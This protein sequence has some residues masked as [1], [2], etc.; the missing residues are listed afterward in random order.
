[1][2]DTHWE[3]HQVFGPD[4]AWV[5]GLNHLLYADDTALLASSTER[6]QK[7][8]STLER[9]A[10]RYGLQLN[11]AKSVWMAAGEAGP[12][13]FRRGAQAHRVDEATYLGCRLNIASDQRTEILRRLASARTTWKRLAPFWKKAT[14]PTKIKLRILD[15]V[16]GAHLLYSTPSMWL[17]PGDCRRLD[18]FSYQALR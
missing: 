14:C 7:L 6:M 18:A 17:N 15:A 2:N 12:L 13:W 8:L 1:M 10:A 16:I 3:L 11:C 4:E 5:F 9:V